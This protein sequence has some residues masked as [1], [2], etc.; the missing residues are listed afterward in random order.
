MHAI[1]FRLFEGQVKDACPS[2]VFFFVTKSRRN[3]TLSNYDFPGADWLGLT[4]NSI[5]IRK[6]ENKSQYIK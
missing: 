5:I 1:L 3:R 6:L 2:Y 4:H